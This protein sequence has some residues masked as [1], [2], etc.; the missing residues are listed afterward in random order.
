VC[1]YVYKALADLVSIQEDLNWVMP[2]DTKFL[3][4]MKLAIP[5]ILDK[6]GFSSIHLWLYCSEKNVN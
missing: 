1:E 4:K 2:F 5:E 6:T 3:D